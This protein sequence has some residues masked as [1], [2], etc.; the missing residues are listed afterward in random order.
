MNLLTNTLNFDSMVRTIN[1]YSSTNILRFNSA[2]T[3]IPVFVEN[4]ENSGQTI[5]TN[6]NNL[7]DLDRKKDIESL[8]YLDESDSFIIDI[9]EH[10]GFFNCI[11]YYYKGLPIGSGRCIFGSLT[12]SRP[13]EF[14]DFDILYKGYQYRVSYKDLEFICEKI[15]IDFESVITTYLENN[16]D[17]TSTIC[18]FLV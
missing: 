16:M 8:L 15:K 11:S 9:N 14:S 3:L 13:S 18:Q 12:W 2:N 10:E 5:I 1:N 6:S 17:I 7:D 4:I